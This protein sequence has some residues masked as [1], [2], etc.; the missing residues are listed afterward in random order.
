MHINV[1]LNKLHLNII[2]SNCFMIIT[3]KCSFYSQSFHP[4][5][6]DSSILLNLLDLFYLM[7]MVSCVTTEF[8][9]NYLDPNIVHE[10][11]GLIGTIFG[12]EIS[13]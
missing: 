2:C 4:V 12:Q 1:Q 8:S 9:S 10:L 5:S 13:L 11:V 6:M 7:V 3:I